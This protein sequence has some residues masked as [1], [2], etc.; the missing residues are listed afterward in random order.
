[1]PYLQ[2]PFFG[3]PLLDWLI[4]MATACAVLVAFMLIPKLILRRLSRFAESTETVLDDILVEVLK[5]T[6]F[7]TAVMVAIYIGAQALTLGP[8]WGRIENLLIVLAALLQGAIWV[9]CVGS[10]FLNRSIRQRSENDVGG[11]TTLRALGFAFKLAVWS[12]FLL[13]VLDNFGVNVTG[14]LAGLGIGGIAIALAVQNILGDL[15]SALSIV[16]DKP[17]ELGDFIITGD[18]LGT[19]ERIG[20]KTT[21]IRS[22]S[23]EQIIISNT[24]LLSGRVRNF[25][26]MAERRVLFSLGVTFQ[27]PHA[28]L[29][30]ISDLV[31]DIVVAQNDVRFDRTHFKSIG[32]SALLFEVVYYVLDPDYNKFMDIQQAINLEIMR[33]FEAEKIDF[34]YPTHTVFM[35]GQA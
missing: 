17:F 27:T 12:L 29:A 25:K 2:H 8:R 11:T 19:V 20:L 15:L 9:S 18:Y 28:K 1:M 26:R 35:Q 32:D 33:R 5:N 34:A 6:K 7:F 31:R 4:A 24:D 22:L 21:R 3:N 23:G 30:T 10:F 14:L 16:L 13:M